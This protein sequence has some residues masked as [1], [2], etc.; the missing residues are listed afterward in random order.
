VIS[1]YKNSRYSE[2][3]LTTTLHLY[4]VIKQIKGN[5]E[6]N[7]IIELMLDFIQNGPT[8]YDVIQLFIEN[9]E[10]KIITPENQFV[11]ENAIFDFMTMQ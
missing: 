1:S 10:L 2:E 3:M 4:P 8:N 9:I 11:M 6:E 7:S 5:N